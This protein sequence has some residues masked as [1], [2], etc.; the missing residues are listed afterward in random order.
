MRLR[1]LLAIPDLRLELITGHGELDRTIR[2]VVTTD[3]KDP[4]RYL[5]GGEL[6]LSGLVW[7]RRPADTEVFV[8]ALTRARVSALAAWD[9]VAA[10]I[11]ADLV[12]ACDRHGL[13]L[14]RVPEDVAFASVTEQVMRRLSTARAADLTA[15]LG[16]HRRLMAGVAEGAGLGPLLDLVGRDLGMRCWVLAPPGRLIAGPAELPGALSPADLVRGL[17]TA[18]RLPAVLHGPGLSLF[19]V[20]PDA[21]SAA[22]P[23]TAS[24]GGASPGTASSDAAAFPETASPGAA[25]RVADWLIVCE[26]DWTEW[27]AERRALA[28]ELTTIVAIERARS[29]ERSTAASH[30]ARELVRLVLADAPTAEI[31]PRLQ[32]TGLDTAD[33]LIPVAAG[34]AD[35]LRPGDLHRLFREILPAGSAVGLLGDEIVALVPVAGPGHDLAAEIRRAL[36]VLAPGLSG[37]GVSV[38]VG[39]PVAAEGL[40]GAVAEARHARRLA[41]DGTGPVRVVGPDALATHALLLANLP[42]DARV[43]FRERLLGPLRAYDEA[44]HAGLIRTLETF[45]Q[46]SGSWTR[47]ADRLH[48]HVNSVRYRIRRVEELTGRDLTRLED[49]VDFFLALRLR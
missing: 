20:P 41:D 35:T 39:E 34:T 4:G 21:A 27:P 15:V 16:R 32:L 6:V 31:S 19:A 3:L 1:T 40:R 46:V 42:D 17:L 22:S 14:F 43:T 8:R 18:P 33:A 23:G 9:A 47:C 48:L 30:L 44:H 11:P 25:S 28:A 24:P 29:D 37:G 2:W 49:R 10:T 5:R 36:S 38:G 7:R 45:L 12:D 13:P 26:G